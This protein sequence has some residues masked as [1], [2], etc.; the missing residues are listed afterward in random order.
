MY[1]QTS[2]NL[3]PMLLRCFDFCTFIGAEYL[4]SRLHFF[5]EMLFR[6]EAYSH[7]YFIHLTGQKHL[8]QENNWPLGA[9]PALQRDQRDQIAPKALVRFGADTAMGEKRDH[10]FRLPDATQYYCRTNLQ[11]FN[12]VPCF[13]LGA[14]RLRIERVGSRKPGCI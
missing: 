11:R 14:R 10:E 3:A 8:L 5:I 2:A 12:S 1:F 13:P 7:S 9:K 4:N 6:P